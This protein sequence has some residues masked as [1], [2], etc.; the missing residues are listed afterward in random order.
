MH[1][2]FIYCRK[3]T[4]DDDHQ[5]LSL[6]SQYRELTR[7]A[8]QHSLPVVEIFS[9][10]RSARR[11]GRTIFDQML[12]RIAKGEAEGIIAWHP[13]RLA[14]NAVDGGQIIHY[15]D[16]EKLADLHFPTFTFENSPQGVQERL[17]V[18]GPPLMRMFCRLSTWVLRR[19][20]RIASM[21]P[22]FTKSSIV[23]WRPLNLRIVSVTAPSPSL[24]L[25]AIVT[26]AVRCLDVFFLSHGSRGGRSRSCIVNLKLTGMPR[27]WQLLPF[28]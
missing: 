12:R 20:M 22:H 9:E 4:D 3:S 14:R 17:P 10:S 13:D 7:F 5:A 16:T 25:F 28:R 19:S 11:P 23:K 27:L 24:G 15:V 18:P 1:R 21:L 8:E 6:E 26:S 2:Y